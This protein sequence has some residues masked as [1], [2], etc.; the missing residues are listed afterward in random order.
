MTK[1]VK[2]GI[3]TVCVEFHS[4]QPLDCSGLCFLYTVHSLPPASLSPG[5]EDD[6]S[7]DESPQAPGATEKSHIKQFNSV[8]M[9]Q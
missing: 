2:L 1:S 8:T 9:V 7:L 3:L 4:V 5:D 6:P